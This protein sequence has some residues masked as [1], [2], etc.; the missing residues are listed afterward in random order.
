MRN[1]LKDN[2]GII[3]L[4]LSLLGLTAGCDVFNSDGDEGANQEPFFNFEVQDENGDLLTAASSEQLDGTEIETGVGL[5]GE[6][7]VSP[8]FIA[9]LQES[10]EFEI[11]PE[12]FKQK[13]IILHAENG[14]GDSVQF[15]SVNFA[16]SQLDEWQEGQFGIRGYSKEQRLALMRRTFELFQQSR[17]DSTGGEA[18]HDTV[19]V[20]GNVDLDSVSTEP[21][22]HDFDPGETVHMNY[23]ERD[24]SR[25][26]E[27]LF[28]PV[29][30]FI[31]LQN[32]AEDRIT[33]SFEVELSGLR[34]DILSGDEFPENIEFRT[35]TIRGDF[36]ARY[37]NYEDLAKLR[38]QRIKSLMRSG[39][40]GAVFLF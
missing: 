7:F 39:S 21:F 16:F 13:R 28:M 6:E 14:I 24:G 20:D 35:F 29:E 12:A 17:R 8:D 33:G 10:T 31:E 27:Y 38:A 4:F 22:F 5:F 36:T 25:F 23:F 32:V 18:S 34:P 26:P 37:G 11:R 3:V 9:R 15:A 2:Y 30:G 1:T 19:F 40:G